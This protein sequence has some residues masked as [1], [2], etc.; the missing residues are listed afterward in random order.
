[1]TF[2]NL[3]KF[4]VTAEMTHAH[5]M[6]DITLRDAEGKEHVPVLIGKPA[7]EAN[8]PYA[9]L[10]LQKSNKRAKSMAARGATLETMDSSREDDRAM[11]PR[12]VLV[13]WEH[14]YGDDGQPVEFNVRHCT[15]FLEAL[16]NYVFDAARQAFTTPQNFVQGVDADEL[17]N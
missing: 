4:N 8:K 7:T 14:V 9:R 10:Q 15:E 12:M 11:Y 2:S 1:M 17:G 16:P 6:E 3:S 13:G 5:K